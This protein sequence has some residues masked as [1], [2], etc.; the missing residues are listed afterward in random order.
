MFVSVRIAI[1][2]PVSR[3]R[4][5][6]SAIQS[7]SGQSVVF[8]ETDEGFEMRAVRVGLQSENFIEIIEGLRPGERIAVTETFL[9][10]SRL[11]RSE[12]GEG[13]GH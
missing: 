6:A 7:V 3:L 11:L 4:V 8:V 5:P 10:K 13:H 2:D 1:E 9:L 12:M